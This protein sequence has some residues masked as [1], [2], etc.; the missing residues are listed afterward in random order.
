MKNILIVS[1]HFSPGFISHMSAWYKLCEQCGFMPLLYGDAQYSKYYENTEYR[2]TTKAEIVESFKPDFAVVQNT[3]FE[4]VKFFKWCKKKGCKILYILHEPY[5]GFK[6]LLKDGTYCL[7]QAV[8]CILNVWLCNRSEKVI[9]CSQYAEDNCRRYMKEAYKKAVRFPLLFMDEFS[10]EGE[11]RKYFSLIGTYATS[12]GSD[13]F[14]K[15]MKDSVSKGYK[16]NFQIATRTNLTEQLK[17]EILQRLVCDGKLIIQHGRNMSTDEING[18]YRRSICCWNG[19]RRT[20]QSGVLPNAYMLG[21]P[22]LATK[23]GS[24]REFVTPGQTGVFIDNENTESIYQGYLKVKANS[25]E[26]SEECRKYFIENFF[27]GSQEQRLKEIINS[28]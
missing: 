4:N 9:V 20:T 11:E 17:D 16:I 23:L 12:K 15:F 19:Y 27:Y 8:A 22:V 3:G 6:E 13:L 2:F 1:L 5:M 26:M 25:K 18:A 21:T 7:K 10:E 14:L 28:I 24:F